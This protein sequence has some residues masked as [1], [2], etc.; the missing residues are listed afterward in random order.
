MVY[1]E[2]LPVSLYEQRYFRSHLPKEPRPASVPGKRGPKPKLPLCHPDQPYGWKGLCQDCAKREERWRHR[3]IEMTVKRYNQILAKQHGACVICFHVPQPGQRRLAVDHDHRTGK[4]R[5]L[6]CMAC[7]R[8]LL[9]L[10]RY[11]V[12]SARLRRAAA[13]LKK[14]D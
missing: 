8:L 6:L 5:G 12:T 9:P 10:I 13:Y 2:Y 14:Y 4:T 1:T 11:H 7:N 3:G